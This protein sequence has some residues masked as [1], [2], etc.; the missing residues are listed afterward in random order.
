MAL[1]RPLAVCA[2]W[3]GPLVIRGAQPARHPVADCPIAWFAPSGLSW[4]R[5]RGLKRRS[6]HLGCLSA[7][8]PSESLASRQI[9]SSM[10]AG[11]ALK[12]QVNLTDA[13]VPPTFGR[14]RLRRAA[15]WIPAIAGPDSQQADLFEY[16]PKVSATQNAAK[17][18]PDAPGRETATTQ[19]PARRSSQ[20][21]STCALSATM[22]QPLATSIWW[23]SA[24]ATFRFSP[25]TAVWRPRADQHQGFGAGG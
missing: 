15:P 25:S 10:A 21:T 6:E 3:R 9:S 7:S 13:L 24:A 16:R 4:A 17:I 23:H 14:T 12:A 19:E 20:K 11:V 22:T 5:R 2:A 8:L 1:I 18:L